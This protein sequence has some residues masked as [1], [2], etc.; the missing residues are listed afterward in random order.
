MT[1]LIQFKQYFKQ[2]GGQREKSMKLKGVYRDTRRPEIKK[3]LWMEIK[4]DGLGILC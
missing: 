4:R 3:R 1:V 2:T